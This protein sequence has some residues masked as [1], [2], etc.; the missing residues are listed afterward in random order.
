M[1][2]SVEEIARVLCKADGKNPDQYWEEFDRNAAA[3]MYEEYPGWEEDVFPKQ[4]AWW[5]YQYLAQAV[6]DHMEANY[7]LSKRS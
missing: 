7:V 3:S 4:Y 6:V 5:D 1:T 2:F